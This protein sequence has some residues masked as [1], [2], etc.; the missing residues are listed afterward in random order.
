MLAQRVEQIDANGTRGVGALQQLVTDLIGRVADLR[1]D[2]ASHEATHN[3]QE[4][5]SSDN[6]KWILGAV[7]TF[8]G[9]LISIIAI[10]L[11]QSH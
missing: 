11:A 4:Q 3:T 6:K 10:L 5:R 7:L 2:V 1:A 9:L 8:A